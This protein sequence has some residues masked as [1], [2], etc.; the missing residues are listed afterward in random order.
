MNVIYKISNIING[1][2]YIG[3]TNNYNRRIKSHIKSL[4]NNCHKNTRLQRSWNKYGS[5]NFKFEILENVNGNLL[6][7][8]Q[9][10]INTLKS[11]NK[12]IGFNILSDVGFTWVNIKHSKKT[13]NKM[14][15]SQIG[16]KN[17]MYGKGKSINQLD[18]N[19][20]YIRTFISVP[21]A[22]K[23]L[24]LKCKI[25][26]KKN[27]NNRLSYNT[28]LLRRCLRGERKLAHGFKWAYASLIYNDK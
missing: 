24:N 7:R 28:S 27:R 1:K 5:N 17:P 2:I 4:N 6:E 23:F 18:K 15:K 9:Y 11:Y 22:A 13:I 14:K 26:R 19:G 3:S 25:V 10:Y 16:N 20:N 8:E 21:E 12:S